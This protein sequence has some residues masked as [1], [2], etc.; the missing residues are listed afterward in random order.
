MSRPHYQ[1][2]RGPGGPPQPG[3]APGPR[4]IRLLTNSFEITTLP[5]KTY[6]QYDVFSPEEK[7]RNKRIQLFHHLQTAVA[8]QTFNPRAIYDG[9]AIAYAPIRLP[10]ANNG[11]GTFTVQLG[12]TGAIRP[13]AK[14]VY[15]IKLT[16]TIG[17]DIHANHVYDLIT[18][19][20]NTTRAQVATNLM[21]LVIRQGPNMIHTNNGRAYF[22][23]QNNEPI[24]RAGIELWRGIFQSV[25]PSPG[26][27]ILTID[28]CTA[29]VYRSGSMINI[30]MSILGFRDVAQL[31]LSPN[32][33][34]SRYFKLLETHFKKLRCKVRTGSGRSRTK[35]I[36]GL[37]ANAGEYTFSKD[38]QDIPV[39]RH[40]YE[41]HGIKIEHPT[42]I[43]VRLTNKNAERQDIV[44]L[45]LCEIEP[46]QLYKKKLPEEYTSDMVKFATQKPFERQK[47][48]KAGVMGYRNSE[49]VVESGM[50][51]DT[52]PIGVDARLLRAPDVIFSSPN[53]PIPL[54]NGGWNVL[55]QRFSEPMPLKDW[56]IVDFSG[57]FREQ[58]LNDMGHQLRNSCTELGMQSEV[59]PYTQ[60]QNVDG[61]LNDIMRKLV[62]SFKDAITKLVIIVI[63]PTNG[64][65]IRSAVKYWG[66][67]CYGI[68]TQCLRQNKVGKANNQYWNNIAL[69]INARLGGANFRSRSTIM[70]QLISEPFMII[71]ADVGHPGPGVPKPSVVGVVYSHDRFGTK[72]S[73]LTGIQAPRV[74]EI[75]DLRRYI[76]DAI[77]GFG[78]RNGFGP[79]RIIFFRDGLSEGEFER[80]AQKEL[81]E[82]RAGIDSVW[83]K[84]AKGPK[85]QLTYLVVGKRHHAVFFPANAGDA[86]RTGNCP[87]GSLIDG[88]V[89]H[90]IGRDFYLQSHA[91]IQGTCRSSHYTVLHDEIWN[92]NVKA[93]EPWSLKHIQELAYT[94]CHVYA[95][96]TRSVSIPAPVYYADLVCSRGAFHVQPGL[97]LSLDDGA[98]VASG[99]SS[100]TLDMSAWTQVFRPV[101][102]N[103]R[104]SMYFL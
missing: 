26:K 68:H 79:R 52:N 27:M 34:Q 67:I 47:R 28:T 29:A 23:S 58:H 25:R 65:H 60:L 44:P 1:G 2:N 66:D 75:L 86:D 20:Q 90:P 49:F 54:N 94:L 104:S 39:A 82:I 93:N 70:D 85:P 80:T 78:M 33:P 46:G 97:Q 64:G 89:T 45:E 10:L 42:I 87:P 8:P 12:T 11:N 7:I 72:Y 98:S 56:F 3:P 51:V 43:G 37:V 22:T 84:N 77:N 96:A 35:I 69:K 5:N 103:L 38:D 4:P 74:E 92:A 24:L 95:K 18:N 50:Q 21:Q 36:H 83:E 100:N 62:P 31:E 59:Y 71:G 61:F 40:F 101:H 102:E 6:Y 41:A 88:G 73:A 99:S 32:G 30:A 63:L 81:Q 9:R 55:R 16:L 91:A 17:G 53:N 14:G 48:I 13:G 76:F 19:R 15:Q 57:T